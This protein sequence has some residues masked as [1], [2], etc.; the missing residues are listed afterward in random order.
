MISRVNKHLLYS[1]SIVCL[2]TLFSCNGIAFKKKSQSKDISLAIAPIP[3]ISHLV[4]KSPA[5]QPINSYS[6]NYLYLPTTSS[7]VPLSTIPIIPLVISKK[8]IAMR[9][10]QVKVAQEYK[11]EAEAQYRSGVGTMIAIRRAEYFILSNQIQLLQAKQL[12]QLKQ[13]QKK[14]SLTK[15]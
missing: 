3:S 10:K 14:N 4:T 2:S 5:Q 1:F 9:E 8:E 12:L 13:Q 7:V 15:I 11:R 6:A